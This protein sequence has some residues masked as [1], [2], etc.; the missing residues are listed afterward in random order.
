MAI[1]GSLGSATPG[2]RVRIE[3]WGGDSAL[4]GRVRTVEPS[5]FTKVSALGVDEQRVNVVV[6]LSDSSTALGDRYRVELRIVVW[7][8]ARVLRVPAN[9]LFRSGTGWAVFVVEGG[10]AR[11]REVRIGHRAPDEVEILQG[12]REGETVLRNPGDRIAEGVRVTP[13]LPPQPR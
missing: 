10:R 13:Q 11:R 9:A 3:G 8:G 6:D 12:V 1:A 2:D 5:G 4:A 7:E